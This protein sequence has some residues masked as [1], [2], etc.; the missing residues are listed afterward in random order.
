MQNGREIR[1]TELEVRRWSEGYECCRS[2]RSVSSTAAKRL[3]STS[4]IMLTTG[5]RK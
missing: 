2:T 4:F 1:S 5:K 3:S